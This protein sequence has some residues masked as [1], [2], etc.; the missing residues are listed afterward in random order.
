MRIVEKEQVTGVIP[1]PITTATSP[2]PAFA[3]SITRYSEG[4]GTR[5]FL[6]F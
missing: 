5:F 4:P 2:A 6:P 1:S 3:A